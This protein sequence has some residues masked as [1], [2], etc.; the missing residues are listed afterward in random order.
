LPKR[1]R[2]EE[3]VYDQSQAAKELP[4]RKY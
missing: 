3:G 4:N 2:V 1:I